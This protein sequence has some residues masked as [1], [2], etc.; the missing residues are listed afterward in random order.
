[1]HAS[2]L[3]TMLRMYERVQTYIFRLMATDSVPKVRLPLSQEPSVDEEADISTLTPRL[4]PDLVQFCKTERFL[5]LMR[6]VQDWQ[7]DADDT[8]APSSAS[9]SSKQPSSRS[10]HH[11]SSNRDYPAGDDD[12]EAHAYLTISQCVSIIL[13]SRR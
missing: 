3:Q 10:R 13:S 9:I 12:K 11:H 5:T 4:S 8:P 6:S 7:P 2:Q 1:M